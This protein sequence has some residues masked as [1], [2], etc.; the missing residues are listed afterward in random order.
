MEL[1]LSWKKKFPW[2]HIHVISVTPST[3]HY[4]ECT[5][6]S[7]PVLF[8]VELLTLIFCFNDFTLMIPY[9]IDMSPHLCTLVLSCTSYDESIQ[10]NTPGNFLAP[11]MPLTYILFFTHTNP[12]IRFFKSSSSLLETRVLRK[13]IR[14][15]RSGRALFIRNNKLAITE[16]KYCS[17][18]H[19]VS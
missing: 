6:S 4:M 18:L 1:Y 3:T 8:S 13:D 14:F 9:P 5:Y 11:I 19:Q 16:W 10:V 12:L 2:S 17:Y 15:Y 7:L